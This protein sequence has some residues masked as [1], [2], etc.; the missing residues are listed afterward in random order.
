MEKLIH[1]DNLR[2]FAYSNDKLCDGQIKGIVLE[3]S[4]LGG[5]EMLL[6]DSDKAKDFA[7]RGIIF[8]VPY[9]NPWCWMNKQAVNYVDE[10]IDV[11]INHYNLSK[12]INIA[13]TGGSMGGLSALVYTRYAKITPVV[14]V[15]NCPVCDLPYHFTERPDLPRTL[16]DA[17]FHYD[18]S[19]EDA[20]MSNSPLHLVD[21]MPDILYH[22]FH[23]D[24]DTAVNKEL[25]SDKF[26][27]QMKKCHKINYH[28]V[29]DRGHCNLTEDMWKKYNEYIYQALIH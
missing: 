4:G 15:A 14:C 18:C 5:Q 24:A 19:M 22:I 28:V 17:F 11:L 25:H 26:V 20:L 6:K 16:Y 1:Y 12:N 3:F 23:C 9:C 27:E 29:P 10:I 2:S 7:K 8:A 21:S 13:S